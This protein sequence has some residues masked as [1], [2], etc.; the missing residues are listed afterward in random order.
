MAIDEEINYCRNC[1]MPLERGRNIC[2]GCGNEV[3]E[4]KEVPKGEET[5]KK[6][7]TEHIKETL[8]E[9]STE[10]SSTVDEAPTYS[11]ISILLGVFGCFSGCF[12]LPIVGLSVIRK[13]EEKN[14]DSKL[15]NIARILNSVLV[16]ISIFVL[17]GIILAIV[18]PLTIL[19]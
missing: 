17:I 11:I 10:I 1:G 4:T 18:L 3:V 19:S 7:S 2:T 16:V 9:M 13:A 12:I 14:E 6:S 15:V 8:D 5:E